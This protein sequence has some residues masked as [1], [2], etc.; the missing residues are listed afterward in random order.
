MFGFSLSYLKLP[1]RHVDFRWWPTLENP[2]ASESVV[3]KP[4]NVEEKID[5]EVSAD[6]F[7]WVEKLIK[8]NQIPLPS[9]SM[10][11]P[12]PSGWVPPNRMFLFIFDIFC[13]QI[14]FC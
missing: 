8:R 5:Y 14:I 12:T 7:V 4:N 11:F 10:Q 2:W 3:T 13:I 1:K 9:K 6:D